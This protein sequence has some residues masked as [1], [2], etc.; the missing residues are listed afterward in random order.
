MFSH[1]D[2]IASLDVIR[3]IAILGILLMNVMSMAAP[4]I[5]YYVP[6]WYEG[7]GIAEHVIYVLQSLLVESRFMGIFSMFFGIG[8]AIQADNF[9][10]RGLEYKPL[11]RR[12]LLWLLLFGLVHGFVIWAGDILTLYALCG[13]FVMLMLRRSVRTLVTT[14]IFL[15]FVGQ[16]A[17]LAAFWGSVASGENIMEVP[18][19]PYSA[20]EIELLRTVWT[21]SALRIGLT[22]ESFAELLTAVPLTLFWHT[23]GV[24]LLGVALYRSGFFADARLRRRFM[25]IGGLGFGLAAAVLLLRYRV[26]LATSASYSTLGMMMIP[27]L[28][29]A[30]MYIGILVPLADRKS[31]LVRALGNTGKTAFT[32]Y[33]SQSIVTVAFFA[34]VA[35][36]LWAALGRPALW[37]YVGVVSI[38]QVGFAHWWQTTR[39]QGPMEKLWRRLAYR[40]A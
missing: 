26:G 4:E 39:G 38:L 14:G 3:G 24:M 10:S 27:G 32:L 13:F 31:R 28:M 34:F 21:R 7:A 8:L 9:T 23:S 2:R 22:A 29:M 36:R 25:P 33:L 30:I 6:G 37:G 17:L 35:P 19:L 11:I 20:S 1:M 18:A 5:A 16:L 12:R 40:G 15:I